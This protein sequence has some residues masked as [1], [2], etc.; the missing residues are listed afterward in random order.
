V[1]LDRRARRAAPRRRGGARALA[2]EQLERAR[3][4]GVPGDI[5]AALRLAA[6]IDPDGRIDLL[7]EALTVLEDATWRL[8]LA[9]ALCDLGEALRVARRR[10]DAVAPLERAAALAGELGA[11]ALRGRAYD[12]LASLGA[13][14]RKLMFSGVE[15]LTASERRVA[16]LAA[17]GR[18]NRDIAQEL[19]VSPKTVENHLGR[20]YDK[21]SVSGRRELSGVLVGA[22]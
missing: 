4:F 16:E 20:V 5:G 3:R 12:A 1:A 2:A 21:L 22:A 7:E 9:G 18:S 10:R 19:F 11:L 17:A 13:Q 15:S 6:R 14:P 8:Q